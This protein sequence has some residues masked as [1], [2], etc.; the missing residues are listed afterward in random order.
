MR[1][2][3]EDKRDPLQLF[4]VLSSLEIENAKTYCWFHRTLSLREWYF[5]VLLIV[6]FFSVE[7]L[8]KVVVLKVCRRDAAWRKRH[9][10]IVIFV[11]NDYS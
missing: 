7:L 6:V 10:G 9:P 11:I 5:R 8:A 1:K 3:P 2:Q 4:T